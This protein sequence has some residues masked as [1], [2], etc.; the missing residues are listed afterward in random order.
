MVAGPLVAA[1]Q[2][3]VIFILT[4]DL[5]YGDLGVLNQNARREAGLPAFQTPHLDTLAAQGA[6]L[7]RHYAPAPVC[8]PSR[9]SLLLGVHQGHAN[10]RNNQFDKTLEDQPTLGSVM[11]RAG[12]ATAAVGKWGVAGGKESGGSPQ[13][14]PAFPTRRGFDFFFGYLDH[15]AGHRHYPKESPV[16]A[17]DPDGRNAVW[18]MDTEISS[19]LDRCYS[20]DL[21]A[22]RAKKWII[23]HHAAAPSQPFFLYLAFTAPHAA[24]E[25]PTQAYP[26]GGGVNGGVQW[27]GTGGAAINTA[28][29][30][31]DSWIHPDYATQTGWSV[32]NKRHATMVRRLD[33]AVGDL[34]KLLVDLGMD[35]NSLVVFTSDNGPHN[36]GSYSKVVQDPRFFRS[37]G[38]LDGIKRDTWE[39]GIRVPAIVRWPAGIPA[40]RISDHPSQFHDWMATFAEVAGI[41]VPARSDGTSLVPALTGAGVQRESLVY[42]EYAVNGKTPDYTDFLASHRQAVR[43]QQQ[44]IYLKGYKGVRQDIASQATDFQVY[45]TLKD[46]QETTNLAGQAGIPTQQEFKDAVLRVRRPESSAP[47]PYDAEGVPSLTVAAVTPGVKWKAIEGEFPWVPSFAGLTPAAVGTA[48][49]LDLA[50]RTREE[51]VGLEFQSYLKIPADGDFTFFLTTDTGAFLRIHQMQVLDGDRGYAAGRELS[52]TVKLKAGL[53]PFTLGYRRGAAGA[54]VLRLEWSGPGVDKQVIPDEAF[55]H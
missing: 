51:Q 43:N 55:F 42:V 7:S 4:D 22:A 23:D 9:A 38:P 2:P 21:F 48:P 5:G 20:T 12:Y 49:R 8:A 40:G 25:V 16:A 27:T 24:L 34:L 35:E 13:S 52:A 3:N 41:A 37:Y 18:E 44:V 54:P 50:V 32:A 17:N 11:Q 29:G 19:K 45:D 10:V 15:V 53:H 39:G 46:P 6:L 26:A 1:P 28:S 36:E 33:D 30:T 31:I 14:S 47:R